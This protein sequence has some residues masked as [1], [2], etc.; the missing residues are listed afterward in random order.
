MRGELTAIARKRLSVAGSTLISQWSG[1]LTASPKGEGIL[2][3]PFHQYNTENAP[4]VLQ[5]KY[6]KSGMYRTFGTSHKFY[7]NY[8]AFCPSNFTSSLSAKATA[9]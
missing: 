2:Y 1:P 7:G 9:L 4:C 6:K 3:F 5:S 8:S